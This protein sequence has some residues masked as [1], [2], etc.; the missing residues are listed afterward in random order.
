MFQIKE[1][2]KTREKGLNEMEVSNLLDE[3]FKVTVI[4]LLTELGKG[5]DDLSENFN[6]EIENIQ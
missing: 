3:E 6:T 2:D 5:I 1:G 4:K